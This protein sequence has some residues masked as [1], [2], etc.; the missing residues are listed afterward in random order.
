MTNRKRNLLGGILLCLVLFVFVFFYQRQFP[1]QPAEPISG[2]AFKLNTVV[3]ITLYDSADQSL[4]DE[5]LALC[6]KYEELFSRTRETSELYKLNH[7]TLPLETDGFVLSPET[8]ELVSKGLEYGRL[9]EG[10]FD[11]AIEP[12][13]SQWDFTSE[14]SAS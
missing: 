10:G 4:V 11:I 13:S 7:G 2:T 8:A 9:S 6:D 3:S 5:T 1:K 14:K 12:L